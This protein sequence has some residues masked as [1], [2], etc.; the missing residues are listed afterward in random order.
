MG[1]AT[2]GEVEG[3]H[4][5]GSAGRGC[6]RDWRQVGVGRRRGGRGLCPCASHIPMAEL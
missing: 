5:V 4:G 3:C 1:G 6:G 2:R